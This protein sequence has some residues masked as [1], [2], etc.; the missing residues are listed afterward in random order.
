MRHRHILNLVAVAITAT[1]GPTCSASGFSHRGTIVDASTKQ[2]INYVL[3]VAATSN[4]IV[5][6]GDCPTYDGFVAQATSNA[7]G[8]FTL[9]IP[10]N[11]Q[12]YFVTY[13]RAQYEVFTPLQQ[14]D[15]AKDGDDVTPAPVRLW[16]LNGGAEQMYAAVK[17]VRDDTKDHILALRLRDAVSFAAAVQ[18]LADKER[19]LVMAWV[20][21]IAVRRDSPDI[22][23]AGM[24]PLA[25]NPVEDK[26]ITPTEMDA[27]LTRSL[28]S[29]HSTL[30]YFETASPTHFHTQLERFSELHA[31]LNRNERAPKIQRVEPPSMQPRVLEVPW[32]TTALKISP[33]LQKSYALS[34]L[35]VGQM[36]FEFYKV[37]SMSPGGDYQ[38]GILGILAEG[39]TQ[40]YCASKC[41]DCDGHAYYRGDLASM[42]EEYPRRAAAASDEKVPRLS[43]SYWDAAL[44]FDAIRQLIDDRQ[45]II[46]VVVSYDHVA[47]IVGD[48]DKDGEQQ[49]LINDPYM[50]TA[51]NP[52]EA[53]GADSN[54]NGSYWISYNLF[55]ALLNWRKS[56]AVTQK[57]TYPLTQKGDR[58]CFNGTLGHD[59]CP[60][61][62]PRR[63]SIGSPCTCTYWGARAPAPGARF[64]GRVCEP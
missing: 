3:A 13:C 47:L 55:R 16:R 9:R 27:Q 19:R 38:C 54:G 6:H 30:S 20:E 53:A 7:I 50:F 31:Y 17:N 45:P 60:L 35:A 22:L 48:R 4:K 32:R 34:W 41:S 10:S 33:R 61:S 62:W 8:S 42:I 59:D 1:I 49:L 21:T 64:E 14:N 5:G 51:L 29:L 63:L 15:N 56:F 52:Y 26:L 12:A 44:P 36:V 39:A 11:V 37:P 58:C 46:A 43:V 25:T 2:P 28:V 40:Q 23:I 57:G 18:R 24:M